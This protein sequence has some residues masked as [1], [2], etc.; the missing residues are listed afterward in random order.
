MNNI[1]VKKIRA[2]K[3]AGRWIIRL[4]LEY[5][6][7]AILII[8]GVRRQVLLFDGFRFILEAPFG[9]RSEIFSFTFMKEKSSRYEACKLKG[10]K[11]YL[12]FWW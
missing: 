11:K 3:Q 12:H 1:L 10:V 6:V 4:F 9:L 2:A 8:V 7:S 5:F